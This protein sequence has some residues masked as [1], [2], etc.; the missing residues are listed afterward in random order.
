M[1]C[2]EF[3]N[4]PNNSWP[5]GNPVARNRPTFLSLNRFEKK[6]NI[7]LAISAFAQFRQG[8]TAAD[9]NTRKLDTA[10]MV[11]GGGYDPRVK[12]NTDTLDELVSLTESLNLSYSLIT[13]LDSPRLEAIKM[14]SKSPSHADVLFLPNFTTVQRTAL[15]QSPHTIA[16]LY[17]PNNEHFGIGPVEGMACG[18]P[19]IACSSGGPKESIIDRSAKDWTGWLRAPQVAL[20][21]DA[22]KDAARLTAT[23]RLTLANRAKRRVDE[24]FT[25]S[26]MAGALEA[27]IGQVRALPALSLW[28]F[29]ELDWFFMATSVLL[30]AYTVYA[31][32]LE[33]LSAGMMFLTFALR[34]HFG[35]AR[36]GHLPPPP[37]EYLEER[38][39]RSI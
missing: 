14:R 5:H 37:P 16:L 1:S 34:R 17:T 6:K 24:H 23:E 28:A 33:P 38:V 7:G 39:R 12:E 22:L 20:W 31:G 4:S 18:L 36:A 35:P 10:R 30:L 26:T 15:L 19:V 3:A 8:L 25:L 32:I 27:G 21:A 11:I 29:V 2:R 13:S 9:K